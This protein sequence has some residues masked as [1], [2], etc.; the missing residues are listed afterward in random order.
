MSSLASTT[1]FLI[2]C[3]QFDNDRLW[4]S[5]IWQIHS[6]PT[7]EGFWNV[8]AS[9]RTIF[10]PLTRPKSELLRW[11]DDKDS[12][13]SRSVRTR[14]ST[15]HRHIHIPSFTVAKRQIISTNMLSPDEDYVQCDIVGV[16]LRIKVKQRINRRNDL[17]CLAS[18][19]NLNILVDSC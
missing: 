11:T 19:S 18:Y 16:S 7:I 12:K 9:V 14:K 6:S 10:L 1:L 3:V 2:S 5:S 13:F 8:F 15:A 17:Q 4:N